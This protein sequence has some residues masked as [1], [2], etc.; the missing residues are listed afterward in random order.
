LYS[1]RNAQFLALVGVSLLIFWT[2]LRILLR[3]P[4]WTEPA[5]DKYCY[6]V[7]VP[8][9]SLAVLF[10]EKRE[11]F[12][13]VRYS[14][15]T[16]TLLLL[17]GVLLR[18]IPGHVSSQIIVDD[19]LSIEF[20]GLVIFWVGGFILCY[21]T[22]A[23]RAGA[24]PLLLLLLTVPIPDFILDKLIAAV[25]YGST[26]V[27]T[28]I[29]SLFEVPILRNGLT[30]S[31]PYITIRVEKECSGIHST[32]A[33]LLVSLIAAHLFLASNWK[34]ALLVF[35][36]IPIVCITNG[37]RIA[38][39]TLLA[40]YVSP[41]I[42]FGTFHRKGGMLFFALAFLL[43]YMTLLLLKERPPRPKSN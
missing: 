35:F 7:V 16:G 41:S 32:M 6:A 38:V 43:L 27:C 42:M 12:L 30:F 39:L 29:F 13:S 15:R 1:P 28:S 21:G 18:I 26:E 23:F 31:L 33:I 22:S 4:I 5:Y 24:F 10:L 2:P 20:L 25:Q 17:A 34:K 14:F 11:I 36:A 8:F 3:Y 9:L 40:R 19:S 37:L